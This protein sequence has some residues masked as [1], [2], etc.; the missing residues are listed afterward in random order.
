MFLRLSILASRRPRGSVT[1]LAVLS[2]ALLIAVVAVVVV[3]GTLMEDR[4]HVQ[5]AADASALAAAADL[6]TNYPTNQGTDPRGTAQASA[7]ATASANGFSNDGVQ[8]IVT[9]NISPANY[10]S[11]PNAGQPLPPGYVEVIVQYNAS[12]LFSGIFGTGA[13]PVRAR[14]VARGQWGPVSNNNMLALNMT[15]SGAV[16]VNKKAN[17]AIN[18]GLLVN[19]N[20]ASAVTVASTASLTATSLNLNGGGG[21]LLGVVGALLGGVLGLLGG[22]LGLGGGGGG[23]GSSS[24]A[25]I[26]YGQVVPDPFRFLPPPNP[27]QLGLSTQSTTTLNITGGNVN[28]N[29][30]VYIGGINIS[31]G[32]SVTL[33]PN[34]N[35]TPGIY[36]L[37]GGGLTVSG[38]SSLTI[39]AGNTAGVMIYNDWQASTDAINLKGS[40]NLVLTP[41]SSGPYQGVTIFQQR[42]TLGNLAPTLTIVGSGN[43]NITGTIYVAYGSVTLKSS[44][45]TNNVG[46]QIAADTVTATGSGT[47]NVSANGQP[48]ANTRTL[49]LVE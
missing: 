2:L 36:F 11:G 41:P 27:L 25:P 6:F 4:R 10:Q 33:N 28:L 44:K 5:A 46:G 9:V 35:G 17:V 34:A 26:N 32:A 12:R 7:L 19:S 48:T 18:G 40:G 49:G 8:S 42:G 43:V 20:S 21:G 38:S 47:M 31:G 22:L 3:G 29:P 24:P 15:A 16:S 45:G 14:A 39:A 23:G 13:L 37:Q 30:G 1:P